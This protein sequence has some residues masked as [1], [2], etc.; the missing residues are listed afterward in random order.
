MILRPPLP[1]LLA[2]LICATPRLA[3][4]QKKWYEAATH[5]SMMSLGFEYFTATNGDTILVDL[6]RSYSPLGDTVAPRRQALVSWSGLTAMVKTRGYHRAV[7]VYLWPADPADSLVEGS[8]AATWAMNFA[9]DSD[10]CWHIVNDTTPISTC[11]L[12]DDPNGPGAA[13]HKPRA[14]RRQRSN[15]TI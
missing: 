14:P 4:A 13:G 11:V 10:G 1:A 6:Y 7:V 8:V 12:R 3:E 15:P 2:L 5:D 9:E